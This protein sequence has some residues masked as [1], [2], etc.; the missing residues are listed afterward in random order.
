MYK[1]PTKKEEKNTHQLFAVLFFFV[2]S[3]EKSWGDLVGLYI[4]TW[5][6]VTPLTPTF[7]LHLFKIID[8]YTLE[9]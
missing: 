6:V 4:Y 9:D 5:W 8:Q 1:R 7:K 2:N 3:T